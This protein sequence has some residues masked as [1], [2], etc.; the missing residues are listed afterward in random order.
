MSAR[1]CFQRYPSFSSF[2]FICS[3]DS[4]RLALRQEQNGRARWG[5]LRLP[6][7][8]HGEAELKRAEETEKAGRAAPGGR[9]TLRAS[10]QSRGLPSFLCLTRN[11]AFLRRGQFLCRSR[12]LSFVYA[13]FQQALELPMHRPTIVGPAGT[14]GN[15]SSA[16]CGRPSFS[17]QPSLPHD[18]SC[19]SHAPTALR[20]SH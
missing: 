5:R 15:H 13:D 14:E 17:L 4:G 1:L 2:I 16:F 10:S 19:I 3:F 9:N 12:E 11:F 6:L 7:N 18:V 8:C 20:W